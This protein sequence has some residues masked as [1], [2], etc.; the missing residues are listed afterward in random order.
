MIGIGYGWGGLK[1]TSRSGEIAG[2]RLPG[3]DQVS[4]SIYR[5]RRKLGSTKSRV[6]RTE[7][8]AKQELAEIGTHL[9]KCHLR[10]FACKLPQA[11]EW[12]LQ[13]KIRRPSHPTY[14]NVR[15][16]VER[17]AGKVSAFIAGRGRSLKISCHQNRRTIVIEF[18]DETAV[19]G[20]VWASFKRF[21][22]GVATDREIGF[23]CATSNV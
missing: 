19:A 2:V 17:N 5:E 16:I 11:R 22:V 13:G 9:C 3:Y 23:A 8:A 6:V 20:A 21:L 4:S 12:V 15:V 7:K 1:A 18:E 14:K 10:S